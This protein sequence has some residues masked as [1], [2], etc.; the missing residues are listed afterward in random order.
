MVRPWL[1]GPRFGISAKRQQ[2][3]DGPA[4]HKALCVFYIQERAVVATSQL[5]P[6]RKLD[7]GVLASRPAG[8]SKE[9]AV[10]DFCPRVVTE[11]MI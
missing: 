8:I 10:Q 4:I 5:L 7:V 9:D 6:L 1:L 3:Q 2:D 11:M